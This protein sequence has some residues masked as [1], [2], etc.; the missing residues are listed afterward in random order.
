V[1]DLQIPFPI[2]GNLERWA[3]QG[4]LLLNATLTVRE[5][6]AGSHQNKG[7]ETFTDAVIQERGY[8]FVMECH[9]IYDLL[10]TGTFKSKIRSIGKP[11][12]RG[13]LFPI[14]QS[15]IDA[16]PKIGLAGQNPG[17]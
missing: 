3:D 17:Y 16:N 4:V 8:E 7:W 13:D 5:S 6:Q 14:P 9:R 15:E 12:P 1:S 11:A 2:S 10:R